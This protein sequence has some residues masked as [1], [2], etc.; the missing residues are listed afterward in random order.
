M[1]AE[2]MKGQVSASLRSRAQS[3]RDAVALYQV[4][5]VTV[6]GLYFF[7]RPV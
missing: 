7:P 1:G 4:L 6:L 3:D 5:L 2:R